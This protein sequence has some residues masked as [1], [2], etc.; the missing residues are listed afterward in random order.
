MHKIGDEKMKAVFG[1]LDFALIFR[2]LTTFMKL[3]NMQIHKCHSA[4]IVL[5]LYL[6]F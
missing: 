2:K 3:E 6:K 4:L 5:I 1:H